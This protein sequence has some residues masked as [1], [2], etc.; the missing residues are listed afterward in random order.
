[1]A[2][3]DT[4]VHLKVQFGTDAT[5]DVSQQVLRIDVQ[6]EDRGTDRATILVDNR[7]LTNTD[8]IREGNEVRIEMGWVSEHALLF[9]GRVQQTQTT[10][11]NN[12]NSQLNITCFDVSVRMNERPQL[13]NSQ[14]TGTLLQ[15]LTNITGEHDIAMGDVLIDP[16]PNWTEDDPLAQG[17]RTSWQMIQDLAEEYRSRAFV[18]V[19]THETDTTAQ[20]ENGGVPRLYFVSEAVLLTQEPLGKLR[21]CSGFGSLLEFNFMRIGS[22]AAPSTETTLVDDVSGEV[23]TERGPEPAAD[24]SASLTAAQT[25]GLSTTIGENRARG[26]E[27]A[28]DLANQQPVQPTHVRPRTRLAGSPSDANRARRLVTQDATRVLGLFGRG[29]AMGTVFLR[30]KG[31][32][33]IDGLASAANGRWYLRRVNHIIEQSSEESGRGEPRV[34]KTYRTRIEATR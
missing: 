12:G 17:T 26:A 11:R 6:D 20:Q 5:G 16:M 13:P 10:A 9:V 1:M 30:A 18:E 4:N 19:N 2:D 25:N 7:G 14:H 3:G 22:G 33:D 31:S 27:T 21:Y 28:V 32:V 29:L 24:D 23:R 15:I 8:A 34:R